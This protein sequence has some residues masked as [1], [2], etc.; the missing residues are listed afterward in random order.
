MK[1]TNTQSRITAINGIDFMSGN[2]GNILPIV[3]ALAKTFSI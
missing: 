3:F 2:V 1:G